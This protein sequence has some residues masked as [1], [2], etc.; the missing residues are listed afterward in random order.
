MNKQFE[1]LKDK[2]KNKKVK[3]CIVGLGQVGLP[4]AL[5]FVNSGYNVTGVDTNEELINK[6]SNGVSPFQEKNLQEFI[7]NGQK[8]ERFHVSTKIDESVENSNIIIVCVATPI[9]KDTKPDMTSL[10]SVCDSLSKC[11]LNGKLIL[12]ES[13][14]PPGTFEGLVIPFIR[15]S[16]QICWSC[17]VPERLVPGHAFSEIKTTSRI[18][19]ELDTESGIL[20]RELYKTIVQAE[21]ILTTF[22]VA[23]ISKLVENTYRDVNIALAN[24]IGI[25]CEVYGIDFNELSRVCNS[26]PRVNLHQPGPGVGGPCLPKDPYLLLNPFNS[27][28]IKSDI[29]LNARKFNDKMPD[30]VFSLIK[31]ALLEKN[32]KMENSVI[33]VLGTA[34]KA[35]VS[36]TRSSPAE[37]IIKQ[38]LDLGCN[39]K[40]NDPNTE[41]SFGGLY[42]KN[43]LNTVKKSDLVVILTD[44]DEYK[45]L[46][47]HILS[48]SMNENPIL[49]DTKRVFDKKE[50]DTAGF[51]YVSV[52]YHNLK[53]EIN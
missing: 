20:A 12:V 43:I 42:E 19:G 10:K 3:I 37:K 13:S 36:D 6:I 35:N 16:N 33:S 18:S 1:E 44:H 5:S 11:D 48:D 28:Q 45:K 9:T 7:K 24:E 29:I 40:V 47:L 41:A 15:K 52:G 34:Y 46:D 38:L 4:T 22:R 25:I 49:V 27:E 8:S 32:K 30:H 2:I 23:E 14:L 17:Y 51:L 26:H 53:E 21:I 50:V 31:R 39:V